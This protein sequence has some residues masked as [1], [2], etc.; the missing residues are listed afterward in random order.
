MLGHWYAC[1]RNN[2]GGGSGNIKGLNPSTCAGRINDSGVIALDGDR[3]PAHDSRKPANLLGGFS[4]EEECSQ[5]R[6]DD[7]IRSAFRKDPLQT[8][9][10]LLVGEVLAVSY[11][12]GEFFK[13]RKFFKTF[14]PKGVRIDSG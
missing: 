7:L 14:F 12:A 9:P 3:M 6:C 8:S 13:H 11:F 5:E 2:E 1:A 4:L 10:S